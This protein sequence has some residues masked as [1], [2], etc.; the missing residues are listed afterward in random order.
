MRYQMLQFF[1]IKLKEITEFEII[2]NILFNGNS[3]ARPEISYFESLLFQTFLN[4]N[5]RMNKTLIKIE[6]IIMY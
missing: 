3:Y 6:R 1:F 2:K 4:V 5:N